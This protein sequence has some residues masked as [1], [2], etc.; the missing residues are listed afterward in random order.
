MLWENKK[1][2]PHPLCTYTPAVAKQACYDTQG[3]GTPYRRIPIPR[4]RSFNLVGDYLS[5]NLIRILNTQFSVPQCPA[6]QPLP[7]LGL[8]FLPSKEYALILADAIMHL[9]KYKIFWKIKRIF[10][11]K[12]K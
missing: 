4:G 2:H 6:K 8:G 3:K 9:Q 12:T 10:E 5:V 11:K 7:P 1:A